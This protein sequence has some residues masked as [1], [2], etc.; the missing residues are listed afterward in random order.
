MKIYEDLPGFQEATKTGPAYLKIGISD[1]ANCLEALTAQF[2]VQGLSANE[3]ANLIERDVRDICPFC[4]TWTDGHSLAMLMVSA[5]F[6][7][8]NLS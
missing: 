2:K 6:G 3:I 5:S 1:I 8:V 7:S 4:C